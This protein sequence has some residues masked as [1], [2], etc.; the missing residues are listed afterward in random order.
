MLNDVDHRRMWC[1][2]ML[3]VAVPAVVWAQSAI[4]T[5][6]VH[7]HALAVARLGEESTREVFVYLPP[8]YRESSTRRYPVLYYLHGFQ[9]KPVEFLDGSADGLKLQ[10]VL[11]SLIAAK[12]IPEF[13]VV[14]PDADPRSH[15]NVYLD[16]PILGGW[17]T[18]ISRELVSFVDSHYR[19][20]ADRTHRALAGHSA[21]GFGALT[22][23][24]EHPDIFGYTYAGSPA[25]SALVGEMGPTDSVWIAL[26]RLQR[27]P[28]TRISR[29]SGLLKLALSLSPDSTT[30]RL[31]GR[32]PFE[33][34]S[35]G[36]LVPRLDVVRA[37]ELRM[38]VGLAKRLRLDMANRPEIVVESGLRDDNPNVLLGVPALR[39]ALDSAGV[40][41]TL[42]LF[43]GGHVDRLRERWTQFMLPTV[44]RWF[45][46]A[47][48]SNER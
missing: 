39:A 14:L 20:V 17:A 11:D 8:S 36:R 44:G 28:T 13:V 27:P 24:F 5:D 6:S 33:P 12:L 41:Y 3:L 32:L 18:F 40:P 1:R 16:S 7:S 21:G 22:L 47:A 42:S 30:P 31:Y 48:R 38:P 2:G 15:Q 26:A 46:A 10:R 43:D 29:A 45:R 4:M 23:T 9:S 19:T 25:F 37:W 34:D 35:S